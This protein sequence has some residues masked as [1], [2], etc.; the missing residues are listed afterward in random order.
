MDL[1][2]YFKSIIIMER[3]VKVQDIP[4]TWILVDS[5]LSD[6]E[7]K[8]NWEK[9]QKKLNLSPNARLQKIEHSL[10]HRI[11]LKKRR[12][13]RNYEK[14]RRKKVKIDDRIYGTIK[15]KH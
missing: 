1:Y 10:Q 9:K 7:I 14:E 5:E 4:A 11:A 15:Q 2:D 13:K 3:N 12:D 6:E 8:I